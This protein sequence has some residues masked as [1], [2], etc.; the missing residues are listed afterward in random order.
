MARPLLSIVTISF[1]QKS[2]LKQTI[3]SVLAQKTQD[4]EYIIADPGSTDGSRE[5]IAS[6][7]TKIDHVILEKDQGPADGLN[8]G[9]AIATGKVGYFLNSDDFLLPKAISVL[10]KFWSEDE[11]SNVLLC[12]G[13]M[14]DQ[15]GKPMRELRA[16]SNT[17]SKL[18]SSSG[19]MFQQGM[20]FRMG[21][22]HKVGGFNRNNRT[23]WDFE[24]LCALLASG[25]P[26]YQLEERIG[27]F[28]LH[29][30]SLTGGSAGKLHHEKYKA[31]ML[32]IIQKY[33]GEPANSTKLSRLM[34]D[35]V[36]RIH[37]FL[38]I[39][40]PSRLSRRFAID[41]DFFQ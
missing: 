27:A 16:T 32:R 36:W 7:G 15:T 10:R 41:N 37:Q 34:S 22:F 5:L 2:F 6:Y 40:F 13:W 18:I 24:L 12:N 14:V 25:K 35:P 20:S 8:K 17:F 26:A 3:E 11:S 39:C 19:S 21:T 38:D 1:N 9:F 29:N 28:R 23:C 30:A 4:V 33:N 31:D